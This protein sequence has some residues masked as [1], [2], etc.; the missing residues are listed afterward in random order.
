[1][2]PVLPAN[3]T[4]ACERIR[5]VLGP[6]G[7]L[8]APADVEPY[9]VDFRGLYRGA[10]PLV[11]CP[12]S[13]ADVAAVLGICHELGVAVVPHGGNTSYCGG[14]TPHESGDE[15]VLS[16]RRL[17]R[18]R[19]VDADN[20]S[21]TVEAGCLLADVQA[22][23]EA[24]D[25]FFPLALGSAGSCQIGGN[26]ATNAGGLNAV[27]YGV[28]RDL[29]LGLEVVLAD[30]RVID[31]LSSLRKDN[32]GYDLRDLFIGAEGTL[33]VI[34]AASLKLFPRQRTIATALLA[35]PD[36]G[37]AVQ[38]L[39][40][41]RTAT[42]DAVTTFEFLPRIAVE[43]TVH[44]IQGVTDPL[45]KPYEAY[46]LCEIATARD[47]PALRGLLEDALGDAMTDG[48][49]LDAVLAESLAQ[50][51]ALWK[52]RES[53]PEAQRADGASIKHDVSVPVAALPRFM[54]EATAAVLA[55]VPAGRM[56]T[57]GHVGDGNLHFNVSVPLGEDGT[58]F[59]RHAPAINEA[60]HDIVRRYRGS[61]SA[62]HGIGRL[63][64]AALARHKGH[65]EIEVMR[66]IKHAL[67]P[68]GILNPGKVLPEPDIGH[69]N[70][71]GE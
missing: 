32:T 57:Y 34:T 4:S 20:F 46:V 36:I 9:R 19:E 14:A 35:V 56:V 11:A 41:M 33:G 10:T 51:A 53:V 38:L 49:V 42:G 44:H 17:D 70:L 12:A 63:K 66:A 26:L 3:V 69:C 68:K 16:L 43:L 37:A 64:R 47:D 27:R 5:A 13:T 52:L 21:I 31:G 50:R 61:I 30:G 40:R 45:D 60:V 71:Q 28:A 59:L 25:R 62:E 1:M 7:Y 67:D 15:I 58:A 65:V 23:A 22:A 24:A 8:D 48:L 2:P 18:V 39:A 29:A 54:A 55:I 6:A